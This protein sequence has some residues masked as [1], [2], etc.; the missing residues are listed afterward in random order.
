MSALT[1]LVESAERRRAIRNNFSQAKSCLQWVM[2]V[3]LAPPTMSQLPQIADIETRCR[4][5]SRRARTGHLIGNCP[6]S[7]VVGGFG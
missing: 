1:V 7:S 5:R 6:A 2:S 3:G 4:E